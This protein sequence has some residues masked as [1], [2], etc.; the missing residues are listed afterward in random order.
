MDELF[1]FFNENIV[2]EE[3]IEETKNAIV[4]CTAN[5]RYDVVKEEC[6][7]AGFRLS[8]VDDYEWDLYWCDTRVQQDQ[9]ARL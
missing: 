4:L 5:T 3:V 2:E 6:K 9:Y 1:T 8:E 7:K